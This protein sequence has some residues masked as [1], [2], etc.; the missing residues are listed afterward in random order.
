MSLASVEGTDFCCF[1]TFKLFLNGLGI[2]YLDGENNST[3][4]ADNNGAGKTSIFKSITWVLYGQT[5]DGKDGDEV[6]RHG[7]KIARVVAILEHAGA[8]WTVVRER[9]KGSPKLQL[10]QPDG[11]EWK[12]APKELQEKIITMVGL[13]FKAF[14][15]TALYG[16]GDTTRFANPQT[17]D[18]ERK[19]I[20]HRIMGTEILTDCHKWIGKKAADINGKLE[21][22]QTERDKVAAQAGE[23]DVES[24][25][26]EH[27]AWESERSKWLGIFKHR[28]TTAKE[29]ALKHRAAAGRVKEHQDKAAELDAAVAAAEAAGEDAERWAIKF[30]AALDVH[31]TKHTPFNVYKAAYTKTYAELSA[32]KGEL[33]PTCTTP[34]AEGVAHRH[35]KELE[36][37]NAGAKREMDKAA[38]ELTAAQEAVDVARGH[39]RDAREK[40]KA[41]G[42]LL[43]ES[44]EV[45]QQMAEAQQ[46]E[47][48]TQEAIK[49]AQEAADGYNA[50]KME[51]NPHAARLD[52]AKKKVALYQARLKELAAAAAK[53]EEE[54]A[55]IQFWVRGFSGQG[56]PSFVLDS[57]MPY[58]TDRANHYLETL[59]DGDITLSFST[60]RELKSAKGEVRDQIAIHAEIG[61]RTGYP[62]SNA[63]QKKID[64]ATDL[65]LMD[66]VAMREGGHVNILLFDEVLDGF[67]KTGRARVLDLLQEL[68]SV[69]SSIFVISHEEDMA[70]IFEKSVTAVMDTEGVS[71]VRVSA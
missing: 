60:Q 19:G 14:C 64:I 56:L 63:Q 32:L 39:E 37:A 41:L 52:A 7:A 21:A 22:I 57:V 53:E 30:Q 66:L 40:A 8:N 25:Q 45:R 36:H 43:L 65:A 48:L 49:R 5:L 34:L 29:E 2:V 28:L 20:L 1:S 31:R 4:A 70:E 3:T 9:R 61:G 6:I 33:C 67:D 47:G 18:P 69:R 12:G 54:L 15:A 11:E 16:Q 24:I 59:A 17:K 51:M 68:R 10:L 62:P 50:K 46:A 23:H 44:A 35:V 38:L 13:D 71:T 42:G 55:H 27:G 58:L 26:A